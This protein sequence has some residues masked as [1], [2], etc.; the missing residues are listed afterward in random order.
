MKIDT[1]IIKISARY[2]SNYFSNYLDPNFTYHNILHTT[3]VAKAVNALCTIMEVNEHQRNVL[4]LSAWF[5]D[6]G[7]AVNIEGHEQAGAEL[8]K[9]FLQGRHVAEEDIAAVKTCILSTHYPQKPTTLLQEIICDADL[10]YLGDNNY[11]TTSA[12]LRKEWELTKAITYRDAEW[13]RL[14]IHFVSTHHFHTTYCRSHTEEKKN[15]NVKILENLL[16][17]AN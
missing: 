8:A 2:V 17:S 9:D 6:L 11:F 12:R 5:H 15:K 7:F 14:N 10:M 13:Y 1:D 16:L 3:Y 4:L